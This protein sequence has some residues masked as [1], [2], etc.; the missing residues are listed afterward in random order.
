M[1]TKAL[2][3]VKERREDR[4]FQPPT[5]ARAATMSYEGE[6]RGQDLPTTYLCTGCFVLLDRPQEIGLIVFW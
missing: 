3:I 2:K 5:R 6:K 1:K 4:A